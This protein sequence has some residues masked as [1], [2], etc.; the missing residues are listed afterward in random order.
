MTPTSI[1]V[2]NEILNDTRPPASSSPQDVKRGGAPSCHWHHLFGPP[3]INPLNGK[4]YTLPMFN[5]DNPYSRTFHLSWLGFFAA[6]LSWFAFP[7]LMPVAIK[8]DLKLSQA[9]IANSNIVALVATLF[10]RVLS[11][12]VMDRYGPRKVMA[13]LLILGAIPSGLAG[14]A[15]NA[16][17]LYVLRFCIGSLGGT[18]IP[19]QAWTSC[20]FDKIIIGRANGFVAGWG[21]MGGGAAFAIMVSTYSSL[22]SEGLSEHSAWRVAFAVVPVPILLSVAVLRVLGLNVIICPPLPSPLLMVTMS[23]RTPTRR[24]VRGQNTSNRGQLKLAKNSET[25]SPWLISP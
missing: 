20:F 9:E 13:G 6:F 1:A 16:Q 3:I 21:N 12:P 4:S 25:L 18:F 22:R 5:L 24:H 14:T 2:S 7:P 17:T 10:V 23:T 11:G 15:H 8:N 19:C